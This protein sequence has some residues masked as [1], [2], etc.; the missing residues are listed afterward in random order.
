MEGEKKKRMIL[1]FG[2]HDD[3]MNG[4]KGGRSSGLYKEWTYD[5]FGMELGRHGFGIS[6]LLYIPHFW[7]H[8]NTDWAKSSMRDATCM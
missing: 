1:R 6:T 2:M 7:R 8:V 5:A 3:L 4:T